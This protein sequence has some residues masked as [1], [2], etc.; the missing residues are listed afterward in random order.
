MNVEILLKIRDILW[1]D[2]RLVASHEGLRFDELA[3]GSC[4]QSWFHKRLGNSD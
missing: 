1:L 4:E 3:A 2:E